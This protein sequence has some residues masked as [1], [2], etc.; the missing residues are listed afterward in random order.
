MRCPHQ[1][2]VLRRTQAAR[3]CL[4]GQLHDLCRHANI[5]RHDIERSSDGLGVVGVERWAGGC[6]RR[7]FQNAS[8]TL[9]SQGMLCGKIAVA[10]A[11]QLGHAIGAEFVAQVGVV[12]AL[13]CSAGLEQP[14]GLIMRAQRAQVAHGRIDQNERA[15]HHQPQHDVESLQPRAGLCRRAEDD[16]CIAKRIGSDQ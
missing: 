5:V 9:G 12:E 2:A 11:L 4:H 8:N 6:S 7:V 1:P 13:R 14:P 15:G 3:A 16:H 10:Q